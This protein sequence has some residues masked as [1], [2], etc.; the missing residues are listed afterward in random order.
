MS[1]RF[2]SVCS[3]AGGL[4][5]GFIDSNFEPLLLNDNDEQCLETIKLNHPNVNTH[6]GDMKRINLEKYRDAD[7]GTFNHYYA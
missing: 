3:G 7:F 6:F 5:K 1:K 2:I 4:C